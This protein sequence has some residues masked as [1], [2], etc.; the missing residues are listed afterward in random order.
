VNI[1]T[2]QIL[3]F[4]YQLYLFPSS[5]YSSLTPNSQLSCSY[6]HSAALGKRFKRISVLYYTLFQCMFILHCPST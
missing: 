3:A 4:G 6:Y 5:C 2:Q 1:A